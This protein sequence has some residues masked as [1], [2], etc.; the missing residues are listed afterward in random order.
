MT[1]PFPERTWA[2][3][4]I[5][6][7]FTFVFLVHPTWNRE[8]ASPASEVLPVVVEIQ[9][10][11]RH[12]DRYVLP[13]PKATLGEVLRAA[14]GVRSGAGERLSDDFLHQPVSNG[15]VIRVSRTGSG[16]HQFTMEPMSASM[17]LLLGIRLDV[18][19]ATFEELLSIPRMNPDVARAIVELRRER[20]LRNMEELAR[21]PGVGPRT[22]ERWRSFLWV[23]SER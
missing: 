17:R 9:G 7:A 8:P 13:G 16:A 15:M 1:L 18:N 2:A 20:P 10:D 23:R 19:E 14:G 11:V 21:I 6:A 5:M 12:P 3:A 4:I 22:V